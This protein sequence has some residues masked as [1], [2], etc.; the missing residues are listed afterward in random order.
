MSER[1]ELHRGNVGVVELSALAAM[2]GL[3]LAM[4]GHGGATALG[5]AALGAAI[6]FSRTSRSQTLEGRMQGALSVSLGALWAGMM[7][8]GMLASP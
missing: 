8:A 5:A 2:I 7:I 1:I 4:L 3:S 6:G